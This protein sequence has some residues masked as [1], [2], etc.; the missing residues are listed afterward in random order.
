MLMKMKQLIL[1]MLVLVMSVSILAVPASA[2]A[3][4]LTAKI[5]VE[6]KI[7]GYQPDQKDTYE[8]HV[9]PDS[10]SFPMPSGG[11]NGVY[12][13]VGPGTK[14]LVFHYQRLGVYTYTI[15]QGDCGNGDCYH[16]YSIY[17]LTVYVLNAK[18]PTDNHRFDV[19][20]V[21]KLRGGNEADKPEKVLFTNKYA[22]PAE[23][24]LSA[25]KI[26]NGKTPKTG[27]FDFRLKNGNGKTIETVSN[28]GKNVTF[29]PI[30]FDRVG[31]YTYK[32]S[33]VIGDHAYMIYDKSVY[34]ATVVV[35]R[36]VEKQG[37]YEAAVSYKKGT[38][39]CDADDLIF[40]N[41]SE[42]GGLP[43]TGDAF[44]LTMWVAIMVVSLVGVIVLTVIWLKKR[45][46]DR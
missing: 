21:L 25:L 40:V 13:I 4:T 6:V 3:E 35:T 34:T 18:N 44:R 29:T 28:V 36:D 5:N 42:T 31:T 19:T 27:R 16:D 1:V 46:K 2:E 7:D 26:Y 9:I 23:V 24:T 20:A 11:E 38:K 37:N 45:K 30:V 32:I 14:E 10:S 8:I 43:F 12:K 17:D 41:K 39:A 22:K 15:T 33:E